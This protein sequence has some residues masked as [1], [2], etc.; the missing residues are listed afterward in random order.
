MAYKQNEL[1]RFYWANQLARAT[2]ARDLGLA[3][4]THEQQTAKLNSDWQRQDVLRGYTNNRNQFSG[5][6]NKRGMMN[7]GAYR[8]QLGQLQTDRDRNLSRSTLGWNQQQAGFN[9]AGTQLNRVH[10]DTAKWLKDQE[11]A[12]IKSRAAALQQ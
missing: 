7:S 4:N 6:W 8:S 10:S 1:E 5:S 3:Q 2:Q 9:L 12:Y 11:S